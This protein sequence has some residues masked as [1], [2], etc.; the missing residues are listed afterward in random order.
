MIRLAQ[1]SDPHLAG[2]ADPLPFGQDSAASLAA[3]VDAFQARPDVAVITGDLTENG[4]AEAYRRVRALTAGFA[5]EM[6]AVAGNHDDRVAMKEALG[7]GED[8]RV[9]RL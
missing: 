8:L 3:M 5:D 7:A 9:V 1:L 4:S 2:V 6:H